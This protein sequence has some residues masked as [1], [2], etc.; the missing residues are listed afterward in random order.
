MKEFSQSLTSTGEI[1]HQINEFGK[2]TLKEVQQAVGEAV[3]G[4]PP[5][6]LQPLMLG[7]GLD[8]ARGS[9]VTNIA[10]SRQQEGLPVGGSGTL[11]KG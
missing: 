5:P 1:N 3:R 10:S 7:L 8:E 4:E 11:E 6:F 2:A 9:R